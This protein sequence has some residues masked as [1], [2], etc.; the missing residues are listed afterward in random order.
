MLMIR[1]PSTNP[2]FNLAADEYM[3]TQMKEEIVSLWRNDNAVI[4]GRNQNAIQ[5]MDLDYIRENQITVIRRLTG[6]GAVFH[7]LGNVNFTFIQNHSA[8]SFNDYARFTAPIC[9]YLRTLGLDAQ[10]S[11]RNDLLV[12]GMK[13]SGN[14]QTIRGGRILHHG[15]LLFSLNMSKL[16]GALRPRPIKIESKG[17]QSVRSRV[18]NISSHLSQPMT[19]EEFLA[20]LEDYLIRTIPD[21]TAREL[22]Q[23]EKAAVTKLMEEKYGTWEWNFG[24]SPQYAFQRSARYPFGIVDLFLTVKDG[25]LTQLEIYGD[26]FGMEDKSLLEERLLGVRHQREAVLRRLEDFPVG[27]VIHGMT[28][29]EFVDLLC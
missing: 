22:T 14:A 26:F 5:E 11:G 6:G 25:T 9:G 15:T 3:L 4:I 29:E 23:E 28:N 17:I 2:A 20:G 1:N 27:R 7:D 8:G 21:L 18:T 24:R 10:L 12:D 13:I 16:A 19:V